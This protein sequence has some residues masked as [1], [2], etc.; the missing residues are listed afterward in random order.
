MAESRL[1]GHSDFT[2]L[3]F[4]QTV[5]NFGDRISRIALP[6]IAI[7]DLHRGAFEVGVLA[8]LGALPFL[9]LSPIAGAWIDRVSRRSVLILADLGRL[10]VLATVPVAYWLDVLSM[11][12]LFV[13]AGLTAILTV[14]FEV[15]YQAYLPSLVGRD[16]IM[17]GNQKL[18]I[19]RSMATVGGAAAG[20]G[21]MQA[22]GNAVAVLVDALSF[23]VSLVAVVLIKHR[24]PE[25]EKT[26][27]AKGGGVLGGMRDG[28]GTVLG[29]G[30]LRN[31][32]LSTTL[33][34]L[35]S[36]VATPLVLL[37][38]YQEASLSQVEVG[39]AFAG[40]GIG[41]ILGG[42][43]A[44]KVAAIVTVS[45]ALALS[46]VMVGV[47]I[48][49]LPIAGVSLALV[50]LIVSQFLLGFAYSVYQIH[51]LSLVQTLVPVEMLGRV[52]G[53]ALSVVWGMA[54]FG[55]VLAGVL[56]STV[57]VRL[58]LVIAGVMATVSVLCILLS[59]L[60]AVRDLQGQESAKVPAKA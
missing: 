43:L 46:I 57:G 30:R 49:V 22:V 28:F 21:L 1:R 25:P 13:V 19:S 52:N 20:G 23:L 8:L 27:G 12:H 31:L 59:P 60:R 36:G 18:Q 29:D 39:I 45:G 15:A 9:L 44:K 40:A 56:G 54:A 34:N 38:A 17:E 5:S 24:E 3:W 41:M 47:A 48:L 55:G 14:F 51:V 7:V 53:A 50:A 58:S 37:Y 26:P 42:V 4:G 6:T 10:V 35:A 33:V 32:M 16:A 11:A 2:K